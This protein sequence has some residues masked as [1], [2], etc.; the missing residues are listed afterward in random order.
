M[1]SGIIVK[2]IGGFYYVEAQ[3]KLYECKARGIFRKEEIVP[4]PGDQVVISIIDAEKRLGIIDEILPRSS[5]LIRPAVANIN[6]VVMVIAAKSPSPDMMLLDKLLI[7]AEYK[8]LKSIICINKVDL[9]PEGKFRNIVEMYKKPGYTVIP[10]SIVDNIGFDQLRACLQDKT[11]VFAGQSGVGKSTLLNRVMNSMVMKIG[12]I[13]ERNERGKHTTRHAELL[14]LVEGGFIVDTPGFSS[15]EL[16]GVK[17][18][19][20]QFYYPEMEECKNKCRFTG[21]SHINEPDC[22]VKE[23]VGDG[24]MDRSRYD[25]YI[26]LH[27]ILKEEKDNEYKKKDKRGCKK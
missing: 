27:K 26:E 17:L 3:N 24:R 22:A 8:D 14:K 21:C 13:S 20:L 25:R 10:I 7:T 11:S 9:D 16:S 23:A 2:G 19:E 12:E 4:L 6:Q 1:P 18:D 5:L 15:F